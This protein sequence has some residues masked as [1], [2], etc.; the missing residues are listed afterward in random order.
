MPP[1]RQIHT[2]AS[3]NSPP[4]TKPPGVLIRRFRFYAA[5]VW[6][7][8]VALHD[9]PGGS[10]RRVAVRFATLPRREEQRLQLHART[11]K[12]ALRRPR[13]LAENG[14][15]RLESNPTKPK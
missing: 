4:L 7:L 10:R 1:S 9:L 11:G 8:A 5:N 13:A 15:A 14:R 12:K 2:A 3:R 6:R